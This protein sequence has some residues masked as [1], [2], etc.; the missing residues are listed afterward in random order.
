MTA[1]GRKNGGGGGGIQSTLIWLLCSRPYITSYLI[2]LYDIIWALELSYLHLQPK[3]RV[4]NLTVRDYYSYS[5]SVFR[6]SSSCSCSDF[7][8]EYF[9]FWV[10]QDVETATNTIYCIVYRKTDGC[11]LRCRRCWESLKST[12]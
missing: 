2:S 11:V 4:D 1:I 3:S 5:Y 12:S 9:T 10:F 8:T 7:R 6:Y